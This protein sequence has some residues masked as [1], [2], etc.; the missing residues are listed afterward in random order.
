M[1]T[2]SRNSHSAVLVALKDGAARRLLGDGWQ[3]DR[4]AAYLNIALQNDIDIKARI[5]CKNGQ[6]AVI[7]DSE[8]HTMDYR[9][10][11]EKNALSEPYYGPAVLPQGAAWY[12]GETLFR[13]DE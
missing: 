5:F 8:V 4:N 12:F 6:R 9:R 1:T 3:P 10:S 7:T 13:L 11:G 2:D